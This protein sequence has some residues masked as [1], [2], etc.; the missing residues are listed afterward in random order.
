[1]YGHIPI[2]LMIAQ[3]PYSSRRQHRGGE[4]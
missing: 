2:L 4:Q 1:M 3:S